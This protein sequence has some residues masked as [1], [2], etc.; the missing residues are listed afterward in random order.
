MLYRK[1]RSGRRILCHT[2]RSGDQ[3]TGR[4]AVKQELKLKKLSD[5]LNN[6]EA[7][8]IGQ[9]LENTLAQLQCESLGDILGSKVAELLVVT[10]ALTMPKAR[11]YTLG[12]TTRLNPEAPVLIPEVT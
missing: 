9:M 7:K 4:Q 6:V 2:Q 11:A 8:T 5:K 3:S 10:L 12:N 1:Q